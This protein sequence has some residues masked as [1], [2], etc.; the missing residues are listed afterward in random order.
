[1]IIHI[2]NHLPFSQK[3]DAYLAQYASTLL[4]SNDRAGTFQPVRSLWQRLFHPNPP[5]PVLFPSDSDLKRK[6]SLEDPTALPKTPKLPR[7]R[8]DIKFQPLGGYSDSDSDSDSDMDT[9]RKFPLRENLP[10]QKPWVSSLAVSSAS[11]SGATLYGSDDET[12]IGRPGNKRVRSPQKVSLENYSDSEGEDITT[13]QATPVKRS[14]SHRDEPGWKPDFLSRREHDSES[15]PTVTSSSTAVS[16]IPAGAVPM[17]TSLIRAI[18]RIAIAQSEAYT[19]SSPPPLSPPPLP[20]R[21][22]DENWRH[23]WA[24]VHKKAHE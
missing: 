10:P 19:Y 2:L 16:H 7:K 23:F 9:D 17:T 3:W 20:R 8:S 11:L 21:D 18:D 22:P 1:L 13:P 24:R 4:N 15:P 6:S 12:G 5:N 14:K